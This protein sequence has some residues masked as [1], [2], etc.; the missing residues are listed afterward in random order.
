MCVKVEYENDKQDK[1][2]KYLWNVCMEGNRVKR[3]ETNSF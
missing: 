3:A 1:I 2:I